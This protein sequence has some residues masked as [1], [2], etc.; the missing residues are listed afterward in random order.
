MIGPHV[1]VHCRMPELRRK[2]GRSGAERIAGLLNRSIQHS[3]LIKQTSSGLTSDSREEWGSWGDSTHGILRRTVGR[4]LLLLML[5]LLR[6]LVH[7]VLVRGKWA[8]VESCWLLKKGA[9][10]VD[11]RRTWTR[12]GWLGGD[13]RLVGYIISRLLRLSRESLRVT[14]ARLG[15]RCGSTWGAT[16][17]LFRRIRFL[18]SLGSILALLWGRAR[19]S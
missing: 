6:G 13:L 11:R 17:F 2:I 3:V 14:G 16:L 18:A 5:L 12:R 7:T 10:I 8:V 15:R 19:V 9:N 4:L 1:R